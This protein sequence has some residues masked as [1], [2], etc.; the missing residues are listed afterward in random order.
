MPSKLLFG[1]C[2]ECSAGLPALRRQPRTHADREIASA[3][4]QILAPP[5]AV[6]AAT[7]GPPRDRIGWTQ[8]S[9][10]RQA[11]SVPLSPPVRRMIERASPPGAAACRL[12]R[13]LPF[14]WPAPGRLRGR[15]GSVLMKWIRAMTGGA[16]RARGAGSRGLRV[17]SGTA[18]LARRSSDNGDGDSLGSNDSMTPPGPRRFV[19]IRRGAPRPPLRAQ[20]SVDLPRP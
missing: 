14:P 20:V 15:G 16:R 7:N 1:R 12:L 17:W 5:P 8:G 10:P 6:G 11:R 2:S 18:R 13:A 3:Q 9:Q 4:S 19:G